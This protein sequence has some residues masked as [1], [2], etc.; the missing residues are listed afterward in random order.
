MSGEFD[1]RQARQ[2]DMKNPACLAA[3]RIDH[4]AK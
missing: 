2:A 1:A 4:F 3:R